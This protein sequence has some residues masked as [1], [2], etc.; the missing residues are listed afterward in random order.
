MPGLFVVSG[1]VAFRRV[2]TAAGMPANETQ[3]QVNPFGPFP[4]TVLTT[5]DRIR[6]LLHLDLVEMTAF[7]AHLGIISRLDDG[8]P[9][10]EI[11]EM[12]A[13]LPQDLESGAGLELARLDRFGKFGLAGNQP[14]QKVPGN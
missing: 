6:K 7:S 8:E 1:R 3:P 11:I 12:L 5:I 2:V 10:V 9:Q 14:V 13:E 4:K